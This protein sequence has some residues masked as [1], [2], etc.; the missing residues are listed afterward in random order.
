[1]AALALGACSSGDFESGPPPPTTAV[2]ATTLAPEVS[3]RGVVATYSASARVVTLAQPVSGIVNVALPADAE[4]VRAGGAKA[5]SADIRPGV[6]IEVT[7][8][9]GTSDNLVA[10]RLVLL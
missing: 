4:V 10:R 9:R 8:R 3:V 5:T 2:T 7:G 1:V 6:P